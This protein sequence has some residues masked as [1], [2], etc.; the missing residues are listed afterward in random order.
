MDVDE[1]NTAA[2][3]AL[4]P[5]VFEH[6]EGVTDETRRFVEP[7]IAAF[8]AAVE[9]LGAVRDLR[10]LAAENASLTEEA[11]VLRVAEFAD[12]KV[13]D[14]SKKIDFATST[15]TK[16]IAH[17]ETEL[18]KPLEATVHVTASAEIR[19]LARAMTPGDRRALVM[20]S[21]Q[22][23][24]MTILS[25]L[26]TAHPLTTGL[27]KLEVEQFTR[28]YREKMQPELS[29]RLT[30]MQRALGIL[31][32]RGGLVV[33]QAEKLIGAPRQKVNALRVQEAKFAKALAR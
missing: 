11:R 29:S 28:R 25:A 3:Y 31:H 27:T 30:L 26:L 18:N 19:S 8:Q 1:I 24:D 6:M 15:L 21:I 10:D 22:D 17:T 9:G 14:I 5:G 20:S 4:Q 2:G 16:Q 7:A 12:K 32:E 23:G 33:M 13:I